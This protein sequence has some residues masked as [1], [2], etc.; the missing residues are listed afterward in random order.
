MVKLSEKEKIY[1]KEHDIDGEKLLQRDGK[2][3]D[4]IENLLLDLID[5][6]ESRILY[7]IISELYLDDFE[8]F[9]KLRKELEKHSLQRR[10][11]SQAETMSIREHNE[12]NN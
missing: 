1:I 11:N 2:E 3:R 5:E 12:K 4:K 9:F 7:I 6:P 8:K 10:M